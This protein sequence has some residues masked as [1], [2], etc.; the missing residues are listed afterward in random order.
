MNDITETEVEFDLD[1]EFGSNETAEIE[2]VWVYLGEVARVKVARLG[3]PTTQKAYKKLPKAITRQLDA[4]TMGNK[5]TRQFM[6]KFM[7]SHILKDWD[8]IYK[9][10]KLLPAYTSEVGNKYLFEFRRFQD[11]IWELSLDDDLFN[12]GEV[13][14]DAGN[15][16][17]RSSG[18]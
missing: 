15:L 6:A 18:T 16:P 11:R 2:G 7:G 1:E 5:R 14:E 9:K 3:N 8:K 4:G 17:K 13:E 10:G 12:V